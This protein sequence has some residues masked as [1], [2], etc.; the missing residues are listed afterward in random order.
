[1]AK[2]AVKRGII[3]LRD[4]GEEA[5]DTCENC[6]RP[7]CQEHTIFRSGAT[8]C[9]EC[10]AKKMEAEREVASTTPR[11]EAPKPEVEDATWPYRY[12]HHYYTTYHYHPFYTGSYYSGYYDSYD[13]RSFDSHGDEGVYD[14]E[15][16]A[17]GFY[18]S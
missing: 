5:G 11:K 12:R 8:L 2:C 16:G 9:L 6:S 13:V 17:G 18:D 1:M 4:C 7:I 15:A 14:E 3:T 10:D